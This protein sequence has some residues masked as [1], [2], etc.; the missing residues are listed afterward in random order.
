[1]ANS[2]DTIAPTI[3]LNGANPVDVTVNDTYTDLGATCSE[4]GCVVTT[5]TGGLD[6]SK[7]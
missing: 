1:M 7:A 2:V 3:T 5:D 4:S 6:M